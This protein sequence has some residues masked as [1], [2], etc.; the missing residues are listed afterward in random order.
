MTDINHYFNRHYHLEGVDIACEW[1]ADEGFIQKFAT[2]VRLTDKSRVNVEEAAY[3]YS[4]EEK[5]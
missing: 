5:P 3:Y 1:L 2:P 4:G